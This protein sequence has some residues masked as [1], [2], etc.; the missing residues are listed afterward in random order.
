VTVEVIHK[1]GF[2]RPP[3]AQDEDQD[4]QLPL[5]VAEGQHLLHPAGPRLEIAAPPAG[6]HLFF[7]LE[8]HRNKAKQLP[9]DARVATR[10]SIHHLVRPAVRTVAAIR[11]FGGHMLLG[12]FGQVIQD[13]PVDRLHFRP[14]QAAQEIQRLPVQQGVIG[15]DP[16]QIDRAPAADAPLVPVQFRHHRPADIL[17]RASSS[18]SANQAHAF[19]LA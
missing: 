4:D 14:E 12:F 1:V 9:F 19:P 11:Q 10:Q 5:G 17:G 6:Q 13:Q 2:R 8:H 3:C 7:P 15:Q 18:R 16:S